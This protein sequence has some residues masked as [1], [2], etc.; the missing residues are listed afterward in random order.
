[1]AKRADITPELCRQLLRYEPE[2][3][4][5]YWLSRSLYSW[6]VAFAGKEAFTSVDNHGYRRGAIL[7]VFFKAH[8]VIWAM[9]YNHWP[10]GEIDH[11]DGDRT[12]NRL[13]N[14]R[15]VTTSQNQKN[16]K[17][18]RRNSTSGVTGVYWNAADQRW[19]AQIGVDGEKLTLGS[20]LSLKDATAARRAAEI[21][22]GFDPSHGKRR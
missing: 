5:L 9:N 1:M 13:A 4:K 19:R 7:Q 14:L 17:H 8:R 20:H 21:K 10:D 22:Y 18:S 3:G 16:A 6:T 2:T 15:C 11:I 12:N